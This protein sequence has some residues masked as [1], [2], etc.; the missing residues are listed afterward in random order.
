MRKINLNIA[1]AVK[2]LQQV[3]DYTTFLLGQGKNTR[4]RKEAAKEVIPTNKPLMP[5]FDIPN[6]PYFIKS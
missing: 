4:K 1:D 6:D 2:E 3:E 5:Y